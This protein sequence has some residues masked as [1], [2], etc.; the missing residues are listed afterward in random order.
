M[1]GGFGGGSIYNRASPSSHAACTQR[2]VQDYVVT[3][4]SQPARILDV[5]GTARGFR[6]KANLPPG[7]EL[8]IA[9]PEAGSG[10]QYDFVPSIPPSDPP[11][12]LAMLFGVMMYLDRLDLIGL[13]RDI[14]Q[15]L[16]PTGV[17]LIAEP[18]PDGLIG[19]AEVLAKRAYAAIRSLWTPTRFT[20]HGPAET[21]RILAE[22]GFGR[23]QDRNDLTPNA[24]GVMPPPMPP[25]FVIAARP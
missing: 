4:P 13:L 11:F 10:A 7:C 22:A 14:R 19:G 1:S 2:I 8:I 9:N 24:L 3:A 21:R 12:D 23:L 18:N 5:G 6:A 17:L 16:R 15:R 25:Y 20:F